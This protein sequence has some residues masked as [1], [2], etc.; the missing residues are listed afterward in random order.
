MDMDILPSSK[1][2]MLEQQNKHS[3]KTTVIVTL[4]ILCCLEYIHSKDFV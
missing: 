3:L 2:L 4:Q 1:K